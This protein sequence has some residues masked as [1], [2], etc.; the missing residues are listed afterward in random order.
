MALPN[1]QSLQ[2]TPHPPRCSLHS[3]TVIL[4][5]SYVTK[6]G[7]VQSSGQ[8]CMKKRY[9]KEITLQGLPK[10]F[11]GARLLG[12][13]WQEPLQATKNCSNW[14]FLEHHLFSIRSHLKHDFCIKIQYYSLQNS[15]TFTKESMKFQRH[16]SLVPENQGSHTSAILGY[17]T[18]RV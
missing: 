2:S 9:K 11:Y 13:V 12:T 5:Q 18:G 4:F 17:F 6:F 16:L 1:L 8:Q 10:V 7:L 3:L 15:R 14:V